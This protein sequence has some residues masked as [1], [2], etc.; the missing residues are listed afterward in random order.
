[1]KRWLTSML[2][3]VLFAA[4]CPASE[5]EFRKLSV[6]DYRDKMKA[7]WVGQIVGVSWGGPTEFKWKDAIIPEDKM[8]VW[9][10]E[11]INHAF[12]QDDLYVEMTFLRTLEQ[13]GIDAPIRQAGIDFAN[14]EY[15]LWCANRAGRNNLRS[16]IAP[17]DSGH[18]KFNRCPND[19]D[20]Q[21]EADY[22]GL[23]APGLPNEV[24]ALGNKFG[25]LMNYSDGI[26]GGMFVGGMYAEAFFT[27]DVF[28]I[29]DA[30]LACIPAES[31]YAEMV[32]DMVTWYRENPNDWQACWEKCQ[33]KYRENPEYQKCSNG[34]IDVKING[35]YILMGLLYGK[36]D[37]DQTIVIS[38]R[39]GMDSD[40]NPSNSA[41]VLFT[42]IG[43]SKLP[44]RFNTGLDETQKFS[45]TNYNF[46]ELLDVCEKLARQYVLRNGG[47]I[48]T[49]ANGEE[50]FLIPVVK[51]TPP[52][53]E[54]S[55]APGPIAESRFTDAENAQI[56][57]RYFHLENIQQG[58][59]MFYPGWKIFNCGADME[60][61]IE[62][63]YQGKKNV[64]K[65]HPLDQ[66]TPCTLSRN[67][68]IEKDRKTTLHLSV[69]AH[70]K[71]DW[72]LVV[73]VNGSEHYKRVITSTPEKPWWNLS[74]D[75]SQYDGST[76]LLE[77]ENRPN[78]W[79]CEC[80]YW[81]QIELTTEPIL[82]A[83]WS[84]REGTP[85][86]PGTVIR[87]SFKWPTVFL[88]SP[89]LEIL[90]DG[91]YVA[92]HD[93]FG[94]DSGGQH[95]SVYQSTDAGK[96]WRQVGEFR[97]QNSGSLFRLG[98]VLYS[99]GF[100]KPGIAGM[101]NE[102]I[103]IRKSTDGGRTWTEP[104]DTKTGLICSDDTYY[105]DPVPVL[106]YNGRVW[107]QVDLSHPKKGVSWPWFETKVISAPVDSDLLDASNWTHSNAVKW[108]ADKRGRGWLE[109]NVLADPQGNLKLLMRVEGRG[110]YVARLH[111]SADGTQLSFDPEK[112][113]LDFPGGGSKF[114]IR[115]DAVSKKYW[116]LT[117]WIQP[118]QRGCRTTVALVCSDDLEQW[119]IRSIIYQLP[120]T[121][122]NGNGLQY[123]DW[124]IDGDDLVF[125][126]RVGWFG[127]NFHDSN[128]I[129]FDRVPHFR[130]R[131]RKDDAKPFPVHPL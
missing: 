127:V 29:I 131:T 46:P 20:Y 56:Q 124:Q 13:Y 24:I 9:K 62:E 16:G 75:L 25:R 34:G 64:L 53:L 36:G 31:Q 39:C 21:I 115:Y 26:Y 27:N 104:L 51:P 119:E 48:E 67:V 89:S 97:K 38:T 68:K 47:K 60:P 122:G 83:I 108:V 99:I 42:T 30:G 76:I 32:R 78:G 73:R 129:T 6:K 69:A 84:Q 57:F 79:M 71:Y 113:I 18:P 8:P 66:K 82:H 85:P 61:G 35:A 110:I 17:P 41:G 95:T 59:D 2:L 130:E 109:G 98:D 91:T 14:S 81:S 93:W 45:H 50:Y 77:L 90:S 125:V 10:P 40:C 123:C 74:V 102:C 63:R 128:Y 33:K 49:D 118:G 105:A 120:I 96:T 43:Y 7:G 88:G 111:L 54:L 106:V 100:C 3:V 52:E 121:F 86:P 94:K 87:Q 103:G 92:T 5:T 117:N 70:P 101:S 37:L 11:M 23:I 80:G 72:E 116:G 28:Q 65:T 44:A 19:I 126:C 112:D 22:S 58:I 114:C 107:W 15:A 1:M 55:W 4:I 12:A